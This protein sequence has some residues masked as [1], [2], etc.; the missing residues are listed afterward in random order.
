MISSRASPRHHLVELVEGQVDAVV[1]YSALREIVGADALRS[2]AAADL[3]LALGSARAVARLPLHL[4]EA[5]AQDLQ[6]L[7]LVL[8]LRFFVLLD[9]DEPGRQMGDAHRAV[10]RVDRLAAGAARPEDVDAQVLVVDLDV[11]LLRLG[12]DGDG[13]GRGMDA[14]ARFGLRYPLDAVHARIRI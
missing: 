2:V 8:V 3:A 5:G 7:G 1:G 4:V 10:G 11:D 14:S 6:R 9:D 12:Q 13:R